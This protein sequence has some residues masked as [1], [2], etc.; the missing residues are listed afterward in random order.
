MLQKF[1]NM[2]GIK[3]KIKL[4]EVKTIISKLKNTLDGMNGALG[5]AEEKISK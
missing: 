5:I 3:A 1:R 4:T 2:Q